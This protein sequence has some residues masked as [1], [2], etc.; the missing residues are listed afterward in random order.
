MINSYRII[1]SLN[2]SI[3]KD[4]D[5]YEPGIL[6]ELVEDLAFRAY[7]YEYKYGFRIIE[8][9][10]NIIKQYTYYKLFNGIDT[11]ELCIEPIRI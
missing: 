8:R 4:Q 11:I 6:P 3:I 1:E 9:K 10:L 7:R 2:G 5:F